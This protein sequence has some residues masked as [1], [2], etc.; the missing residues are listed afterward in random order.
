MTTAQRACNG[1]TAR[2]RG[3]RGF[4]RRRDGAVAVEFAMIAVPF[5]ALLFA[6]LETA[7]LFFAGQILETGVYNASRQIR[8]GQ[9]QSQGFTAAQFRD[10]VCGEIL[11][12]LDCDNDIVVDVRTYANFDSADLSTPIDADGN[13][14]F[15]PTYDPGSRN[16]IVVVRAFIEWPTIVPDLG[17]NLSNLANG[18]RLLAAA[19][20]FRN[21]PF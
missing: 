7:L 20:T 13:F 12:V 18:N 17:N 6:I 15:T 2:R 10:A 11:A 19:A 21:E 1:T 9:A 16:D 14:T 8:T 4:I 5:F 3:W